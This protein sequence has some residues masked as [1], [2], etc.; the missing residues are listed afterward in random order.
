MGN[1][2]LNNLKGRA[3]LYRIADFLR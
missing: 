1:N 3:V 2:R